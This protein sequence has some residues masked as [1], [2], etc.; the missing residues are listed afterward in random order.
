MTRIALLLAAAAAAPRD[1]APDPVPRE[2]ESLAPRKPTEVEMSAEVVTITLAAEEAR[3]TA[4]FTMKNLGKAAETFDVGFPTAV[5]PEDYDFADDDKIDVKKWGDAT[6]RDFKASVDG[7]PVRAEPRYASDVKDLGIRGWLC[8]S[9]TFEPDR[10]RTVE[11]SYALATADDNYT[12]HS[13]LRNRQATYILKSGAGWKGP[14]GS[15]KVI[16]KFDGI[17]PEHMSKAAPA[18]TS[19]AKDAWTWEWKAWEPDTDVLL[20]YRVWR[21]AKEGVAGLAAI[22]AKNTD[23]GFA[24]LDLADCHLELKAWDDAAK[25]FEKVGD[26]EDRKRG[27]WVRRRGWES[28]W[29][30]AAEAWSKAEK[31]EA[32]RACAE[33]AIRQMKAVLA[34]ADSFTFTKILRTEPERLEER[35]ET[36]RRWLK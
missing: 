29:F 15:A 18:P 20:Q 26:L 35:I 32:M 27:Q 10:P 36:C 31:K 21:D 17:T 4:V 33:K 11:V 9:M 1:I 19:K 13:P 25:A 2:G 6:L 8:W 5:R 12:E 16:L 14:I 7:K 34:T 28:P 22:A 23:D 24:L 3:V 30:R